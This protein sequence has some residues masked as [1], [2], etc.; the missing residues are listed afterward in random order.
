MQNTGFNLPPYVLNN[1][2]NPD[3]NAIIFFASLYQKQDEYFLSL[4][5][6]N[7]ALVYHP[8]GAS[9]AYIYCQRS[10]I[11]LKMKLYK[12]CLNNIK[13]AVKNR[14]KWTKLLKQR[15]KL[16]Y[17]A[18]GKH[19]M[20]NEFKAPKEF[21]KLTYIANPKIPY[22]VNCLEV[23]KSRYS[24]GFNITTTQDLKIG[25]ILAIEEPFCTSSLSTRDVVNQLNTEKGVVYKRCHHCHKDN[26]LDLIKCNECERGKSILIHSC[27]TF[28]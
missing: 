7:E 18:I 1:I 25:D 12:H 16:C 2:Y 3:I 23:Q 9:S 24:I 21:L 6:W 11:Y 14:G 13:L 5:Y 19:G 8:E 4:R 17:R 27:L 20:K 10:K 22:I 26:F 28:N 15:M